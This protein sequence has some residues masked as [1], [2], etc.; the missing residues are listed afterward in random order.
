MT[1]NL[2]YRIDF[3]C[4]VQNLAVGGLVGICIHGLR[5]TRDTIVL[6]FDEIVQSRLPPNMGK[7]QTSV[8]VPY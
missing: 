8:T 4:K 1:Q 7:E 5:D 3:R 6:S 2:F